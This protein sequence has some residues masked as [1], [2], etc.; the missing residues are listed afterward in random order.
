MNA[1]HRPAANKFSNIRFADIRFARVNRINAAK[2]NV[3]L[4][5]ER[6]E[7]ITLLAFRYN[8]KSVLTG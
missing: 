7:K 4:D 5:A 3:E 6:A 2:L 8:K 1:S